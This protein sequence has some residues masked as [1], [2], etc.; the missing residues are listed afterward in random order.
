[1]KRRNFPL[2]LGITFMFLFFVI[3]SLPVKALTTVFDDMEHGDPFGNGWF[4]FGGSVGGGG[5]GANS[6]DVPPSDGGAFSLE[7]GWGSGGVPGFFGGFGRTY[8][9]DLT[10]ID[11]FN[12]W[13]NPNG[14]RITPWKSICKMMMMGTMPSLHRPM[15]SSSTTALSPPPAPARLAAAVGSKFPFRWLISSTTTLS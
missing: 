2:I 3:V 5:I 15:T 10:G 9:T 4:A 13:I 8:P 14:G 11:Y 7:T 1:M 12:F 6:A